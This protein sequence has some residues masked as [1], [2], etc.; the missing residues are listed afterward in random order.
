MNPSPTQIRFLKKQGLDVPVTRELA[1]NA[2]DKILSEPQP[3]NPMP[4]QSA[5]TQD[6][7]T[8]THTP[9][10][11]TAMEGNL[12][13]AEHEA[14]DFQYIASGVRN[15]ANARLIAAAPALLEALQAIASEVGA[16]PNSPRPYSSDSYL[17]GPLVAKLKAAIL[18]ATSAS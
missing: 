18:S 11:W 16:L 3:S 14:E 6:L 15:P 17:P 5:S 4:N 8:A 1:A 12:I 13:R 2:I 9:G 7:K 10:P